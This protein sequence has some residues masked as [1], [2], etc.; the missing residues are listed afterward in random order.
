VVLGEENIPERALEERKDLPERGG[1]V[2]IAA[3]AYLSSCVC[4]LVTRIISSTRDGVM[5]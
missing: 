3:D 2:T 4:K 5:P 1:L